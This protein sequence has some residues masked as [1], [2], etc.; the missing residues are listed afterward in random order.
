MFRRRNRGAALLVA[1]ATV[2]L[3][4][5]ISVELIE[6]V[7]DEIRLLESF[8]DE[9][10]ARW[11]VQ[12]P[13]AVVIAGL[14][15]DENSYTG[16]T[17]NWATLEKKMNVNGVQVEFS[18]YDESAK[19][20]LNALSGTDENVRNLTANLLKK[21]LRA[22]NV[23]ENLA[24]HVWDW[25]D[26]DSKSR[27]SGDEGNY[28]RALRNPYPVKNAPLDTLSE[29]QLIRGFTTKALKELGFQNRAGVPD[30]DLS[31]WLT[32]FS[33]EKINLNT[34][35]PLILRNLIAGIPSGFV[36]ELVARRKF[37][38]IE[39]LDEIKDMTGMNDTLFNRLSPLVT[40]ESDYFSVRSEAV[41]GKIRK[42]LT[43]ILK[44]DDTQVSIVYWRLS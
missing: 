37:Q 17:E 16:T 19:I 13:V 14:R 36:D 20:N 26:K 27:S 21:V 28:Y 6:K 3:V 11:A 23:N 24:D 15:G 4:A 41:A 32:I 38:P 35:D 30:L 44:K 40:V 9:F 2:G 8:R 43:A 10:R 1:I 12:A 42:H 22:K 25:V 31:D 18:V 29:L 34:A 5:A 39:N 33:D 7:Q